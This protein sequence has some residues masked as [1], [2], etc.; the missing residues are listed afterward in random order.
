MIKLKPYP[1]FFQFLDWVLRPVMR[2]ISGA[3]FEAPQETHRWN[4]HPLPY[5]YREA[6][7]YDI[8]APVE[9]VYEGFLGKSHGGILFHFPIFG[10]WKKYSVLEATRI[11]Q[12]DVW[13]IGWFGENEDGSLYD[14]HVSRLPLKDSRVRMLKGPEGVTTKFFAIDEH[15]AQIELHVVGEGSIGDGGEF[16]RIRLL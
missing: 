16:S 13:H 14:F 12:N 7:N 5:E 1:I 11:N 10:G 9:G 15:G 3:F 2:F 4:V 8:D 6:I